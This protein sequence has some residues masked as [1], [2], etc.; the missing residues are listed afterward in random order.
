MAIEPAWPTWMSPPANSAPPKSTRPRFFPRSKPSMRERSWRPRAHHK[1]CRVSRPTSSPGSSRPTTPHEVF[2]SIST[3]WRSTAAAWIIGLW[4]PEPRSAHSSLPARHPARHA[5]SSGAPAFYDRAD[6]LVLDAT[7]IRNLELVEPLFAGESRDATLLSVLDRTRT[8]MG[9]RLLRRRLLAPSLDTA[10]IDARLD[11]V[12]ESP[13]R[14]HP[15]RIARQGPGLRPRSRA[16][17]LEG[18][19]ASAGPARSAGSGPLARRRPRAKQR[20]RRPAG[21]PHR[22]SSRLDDVAEVRDRVLA[23]ARR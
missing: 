18:Q 2:V 22:S 4:P 11:A 23:A 16:P 19:L 14:G 6:A 12:E 15:A 5:R 7:T 17:A 21:A 1:S 3:C 13:R 9:G 10:E 8:G 20:P